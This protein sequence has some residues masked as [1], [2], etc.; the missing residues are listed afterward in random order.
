ME[1]NHVVFNIN[2]SV[3]GEAKH[4]Y[5]YTYI[6]I[7]LYVWAYTEIYINI[8]YRYMHAWI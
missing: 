2:K 3:C 1:T 8:L 4:V 7:N 5:I 6:D